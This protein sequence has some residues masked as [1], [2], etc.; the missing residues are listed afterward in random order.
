V[1]YTTEVI[2]GYEYGVPANVAGGIIA[3]DKTVGTGHW[4]SWVHYLFYNFSS[5][6]TGI[7]RFET[8]DD[9]EGHRTGFEGLY[10][11]LTVGCQYRPWK[12]VLIRPEV[13]YDYNGYSRPFEGKH[14]ILTAA[15]DTIVRF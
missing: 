15:L 13:R 12:S 5:K 8:F 3:E 1:T 9:F 6:L 10:T 2:Y 14:G 7:A 11:A 4:G